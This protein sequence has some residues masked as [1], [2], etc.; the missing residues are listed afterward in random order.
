VLDG[1]D[2]EDVFGPQVLVTVVTVV[3]FPSSPVQ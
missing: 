1:E 2:G 3:G